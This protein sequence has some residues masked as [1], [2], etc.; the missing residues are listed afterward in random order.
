MRENA[1]GVQVAARTAT[2]TWRCATLYEKWLA[3]CH[4]PSNMTP[5]AHMRKK[6]EV[7]RCSALSQSLMMSSTVRW[8]AIAASSGRCWEPCAHAAEVWHREKSGAAVGFSRCGIELV[9]S[10]HPTA[11]AGRALLY[12]LLAS[13][14]EGREYELQ[15]FQRAAS[16]ASCVFISSERVRWFGDWLV[17]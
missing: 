14:E 16:F 12:R 9:R 1:T 5:S 6:A 11:N 17:S 15:S 10:G 3:T 4:P 8:L 2:T 13:G 7:S